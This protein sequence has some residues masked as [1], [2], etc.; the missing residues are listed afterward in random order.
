MYHFINEIPNNNYIIFYNNEL[1]SC[2]VH[3]FKKE[4]KVRIYIQK[5]TK[6]YELEAVFDCIAPT[7]LFLDKMKKL[8]DEI[9]LKI[10]TAEIEYR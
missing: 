7:T 3:L 1:P 8:T 6:N 10:K 4:D 9:E 5:A 2:T